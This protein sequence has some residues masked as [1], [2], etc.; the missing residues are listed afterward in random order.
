[1]STALD[2]CFLHDR[3]RMRHDEAIALLRDRLRG[4]TAHAQVALDG[5]AGRVLAKDVV[6]PRPVPLHTNAAVDGYAFAHPAASGQVPVVATVRAG[7]L[8]P[9]P[10][11][12]GSAARIFTGA[13]LPPGTNTV[14]MQEDC[15][16]DAGSVRLPEL[17]QGANRRLAGE[18]LAAGATVAAAGR[19]LGAGDIAA[20][21]SVGLA[22]VPVRE[23]LRIAVLSNGDELREPGE[24]EL[25]P[26]EVF[27]SNRPMLRSL[28]RAPAFDIVM[29]RHVPDQ[30]G[31][32]RLALEEAAAASDV[33]IA[34]GGASRGDEDHMAAA[35]ET[36]GRRHMWQ[37]AVKP[38]R[39]MMFGQIDRPDGGRGLFFGLPGNPV[40]AFVCFVLYVRPSL[41]ALAGAQWPQITALPVPAGFR[42]ERKKPD[43]REFLRGWL[44]TDADGRTVA[45]RFAR[46]GSGLIS[47]LTAAT[48]LISIAENT[49]SVAEGDPVLFLPFTGLLG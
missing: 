17:K 49:T 1:M 2:D 7:D 40:A 10:I 11:P 46:D 5:A 47:S 45:R 34:S 39:P 4:V 18:D 23:R 27:D 13:V 24:D 30:A 36:L 33:V 16:A 41:H 26:G 29:D 12:P 32:V 42:I 3:D 44:A 22:T 28:L 20:L 48:G 14:A 31:A 35:L 25:R 38:G 9:S 6:A 8:D 43:R 21:A 37:L 19:I 15:T